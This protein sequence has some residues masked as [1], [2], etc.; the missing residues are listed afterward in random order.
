MRSK[1]TSNLK[2]R[3]LICSIWQKT[4]ILN[5]KISVVNA[6][7]MRFVPGSLHFHF[8]E[9]KVLQLLLQFQSHFPCDIDFGFNPKWAD[10]EMTHFMW[11]LGLMQMWIFGMI[12][13]ERS[14][15]L[16][17]QIPLAGVPCSPHQ[18]QGPIVPGSG[19]YWHVIILLIILN[20]QILIVLRFIFFIHSTIPILDD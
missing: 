14:Q 16:F 3:L 2:P 20:I 15:P 5:E 11:F 17:W 12:K 8:Y 18:G 1:Y 7:K 9:N 4:R 6:S 10:M 19:K 13:W